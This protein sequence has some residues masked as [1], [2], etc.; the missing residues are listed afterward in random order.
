MNPW[1]FVPDVTS[2]RQEKL[3]GMFTKITLINNYSVQIEKNR[4]EFTLHT[5]G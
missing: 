2:W 4:K 1:L 3:L 5:R